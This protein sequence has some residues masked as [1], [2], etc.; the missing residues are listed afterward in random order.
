MDHDSTPP[1]RP[2]PHKANHGD[3]QLGV[4]KGEWST[5]SVLVFY[6]L[7]PHN[8]TAEVHNKSPLP[9][10]PNKLDYASKQELKVAEDTIW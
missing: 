7:M 3:F 10:C 4:I 1:L 2:R 9:P 8:H 6:S 5:L